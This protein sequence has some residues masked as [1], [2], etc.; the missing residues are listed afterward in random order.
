R[1]V[2]P[3][4]PPGASGSAASDSPPAPA[5]PRP[6]P[7]RVATARPDGAII[8]KVEAGQSLWTIAAV[9]G[10]DL[11]ALMAVNGFEEGAVIFPGQDVV[12]RP[13]DT[14][15][16]TLTYTPSPTFTPSLTFTPSPTDTPSLT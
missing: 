9:Y 2:S 7:V 11:G 5:A 10:A 14:P 6:A 1:Y 8:H 16:P 15:T 13:P 4:P 12:I 3:A